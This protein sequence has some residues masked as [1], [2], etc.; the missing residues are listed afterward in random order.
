MWDGAVDSS[1]WVA[2][3]VPYTA[4]VGS[5]LDELYLVACIA[6][7]FELVYASEAGA[8]DK[9]IEFLHGSVASICI[10]RVFGVSIQ[11]EILQFND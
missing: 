4:V 5:V 8:D 11:G 2:I 10:V 9:G 1:T 7:D 3:P 6:E